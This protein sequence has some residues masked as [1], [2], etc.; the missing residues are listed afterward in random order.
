[1]HRNLQTLTV[2]KRK[3]SVR[4]SENK[5][6][7]IGMFHDNCAKKDKVSLKTINGF[8]NKSTNL[9]ANTEFISCSSDNTNQDIIL[10]R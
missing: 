2:L 9:I 4:F 3:L 6:Y 5:N 1:M 7:I 8:D 10:N